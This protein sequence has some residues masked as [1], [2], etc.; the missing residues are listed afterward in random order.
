MVIIKRESG[1]Y[2][3][4]ESNPL[5]F[6]TREEI[7]QLVEELV[8][9]VVADKYNPDLIVSIAQ[10]GVFLGRLIA[11]IFNLPHAIFQSK[12]YQSGQSLSENKHQ[13]V[14]AQ[15]SLFIDTKKSLTALPA[16]IDFAKLLLIDHLVDS[17][18]SMV[19]IRKV[20]RERHAGNYNIRTGCLY[21]KTCT[22]FQPDYVG[23]LIEPESE[24]G[25]IPWIVEPDDDLSFRLRKKFKLDS[26]IV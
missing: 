20:I 12:A 9:Q 16:Q 24:S 18:D 5:L 25:K 10:S 23:T 15:N 2:S 4:E 6:I 17:G 3:W 22:C 14:V 1:Q 11:K 21:L 8:R 26:T 19:V 13:V 7:D